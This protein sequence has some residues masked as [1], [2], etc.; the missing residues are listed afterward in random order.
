M[1][2]ILKFFFN[3]PRNLSLLIVLGLLIFGAY[4]LFNEEAANNLFT[5]IKNEKQREDESDYD[6]EFGT[7][8]IN[9][10]P[11]DS[12]KSKKFKIELKKGFAYLRPSQIMYIN[13]GSPTEIITT[14]E[15]MILPK[16]KMYELE[17]LFNSTNEDCF[18]RLRTAIINCN[19]VQQ[20]V[21]KSHKV[22]E[23]YSYQFVVIMEDG[24]EINISKPK[25]EE[26]SKIL[27][28]LT[29]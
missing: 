25:A 12:Y 20:L 4:F 15:D 17:E 11:L 22:N 18:F 10:P 6:E 19:Y 7:T 13:S 28:D 27:D 5:S 9:E 26:L 2:R 16:M 14:K 8:A 24:S 3:L 23:K 1:K 21:E 29:F